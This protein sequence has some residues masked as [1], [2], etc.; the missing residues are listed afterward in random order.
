MAHSQTCRHGDFAGSQPADVS[1]HLKILVDAGVLT[2]EQRGKWAQY[3]IAA[4]ILNAI[5]ALIATL[6]STT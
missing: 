2:R 4:D 1:H 5:S 6:S 3:L